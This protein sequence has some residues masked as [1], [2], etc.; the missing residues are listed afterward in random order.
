MR[1]HFGLMVAALLAQVLVSSQCLAE[2]SSDAMQAVRSHSELLAKIY[3]G[4]VA[5]HMKDLQKSPPVDSGEVTFIVPPPKD[6]EVSRRQMKKAVAGADVE[7]AGLP[8]PLDLAS[9]PEYALPVGDS[10]V[11]GGTETC[12]QDTCTVVTSSGFLGTKKKAEFKAKILV[13]SR[14]GLPVSSTVVLSGLPLI[15]QYDYRVVFT[16]RLGAPYRILSSTEKVKGGMLFAKWDA[17]R[18]QTYAEWGSKPN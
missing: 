15:S 13:S 3:A 17:E 4:E 11:V 9:R 8:L 12:G 5:V 2:G 18:E 14:T 6:G 10:M 16:D 1:V 7:K